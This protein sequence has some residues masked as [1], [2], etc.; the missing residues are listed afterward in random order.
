MIPIL[1]FHASVG[2]DGG[3]NLPNKC[4]EL[5]EICRSVQKNHVCQLPS[6]I[7]VGVNLQKHFS[8][9]IKWNISSAQKIDLTPHHPLWLWRCQC[10]SFSFTRNWVKYPDLDRKLYSPNPNPF[11]GGEGMG[12]NFQNHQFARNWMIYPDMHRKVMF[13]NPYS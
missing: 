11:W 4:Q 13:A 12:V 10:I 8:L 7:G 9:K 1:H 2:W 5:N 6:L 3:V